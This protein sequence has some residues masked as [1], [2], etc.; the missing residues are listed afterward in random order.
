VVATLLCCVVWRTPERLTLP[1]SV[2]LVPNALAV[3]LLR[4]RVPISLLS[5]SSHS[6]AKNETRKTHKPLA[7]ANQRRIAKVRITHALLT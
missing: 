5:P 1:P 6:I 4:K 3:M 2:R 7:Q